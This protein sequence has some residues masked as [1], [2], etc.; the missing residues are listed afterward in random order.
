[1]RNLFFIFTIIGLSACSNKFTE[2][3]SFGGGSNFGDA[4]KK[5]TMVQPLSTESTEETVI[6]DIE[7]NNPQASLESSLV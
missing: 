2:I 4:S 3:N 5:P 7:K 1:M 6:T